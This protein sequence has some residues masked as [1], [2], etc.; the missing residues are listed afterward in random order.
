MPTN[1]EFEYS[2]S[3]EE[4]PLLRIIGKYQNHPSIKLIKSKNKFQTF[5]FRE[6]NID[7]IKK[8]IENLN[9]KKASQKSDMNTPIIRQNAAF[10]AKYACDDINASIRS[11]KFRNELKEADIIPVHKKKSRLFY[12]NYRHLVSFQIS[13]RFMKDAY[14][15]RCQNFLI[16]SFQ[17]VCGFRK[18]YSAQQCLLLMID[19]CKKVLD[20]EGAFGELLTDLSKA[21]D[22]ILHD[23]IIAKLEAYDFQIDSLRLVHDYLSNRKQRVK[24][25]ETFSSWRDIEY[26]VLQ[27]S[28]VGP[29]LFNIHLC[30]L[31]YFLDNLDIASYADDTTLYTVKANNESVLNA[32]ETSL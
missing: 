21:F 20:N 2:D 31:F 32:L 30:D 1:Q 5:K 25:N 28:T 27:G 16:I 11:S 29:L 14:M 13:L 3:P 7:E 4:D 18:G 24:L 12:V 6:A 9:P 8:Y 22:C 26:G 10:F 23:L 15:I 17:S 19:K